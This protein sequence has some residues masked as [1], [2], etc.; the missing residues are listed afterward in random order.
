MGSDG[1]ASIEF[2]G[3]DHSKYTGQLARV[4][5]NTTGNHW[6]IDNVDFSIGN[7]SM[8]TH[9]QVILGAYRSI[10][11]ISSTQLTVFRSSQTQAQ[12][13]TSS[14]RHRS[15]KPTTVKSLEPSSLIRSIMIAGCGTC[16]PGL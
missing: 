4:P 13:T 2:G 1:S 15:L 8:N 6:A 10:D 12:D 14:P 5:M 11:R 16:V 9:E 7:V 3:I